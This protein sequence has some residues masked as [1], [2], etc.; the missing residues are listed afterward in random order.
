MLNPCSKPRRDYHLFM[1]L[2]IEINF[3]KSSSHIQLRP[4]PNPFDP[5][6]LRFPVSIASHFTTHCPRADAIAVGRYPESLCLCK[7]LIRRKITRDVQHIVNMFVKPERGA[8]V[9]SCWVDGCKLFCT[10]DESAARGLVAGTG[11]SLGL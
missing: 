1:K 10:A 3:K 5:S 4:S 2:H 6:L 7:C 8:V 9:E 11:K